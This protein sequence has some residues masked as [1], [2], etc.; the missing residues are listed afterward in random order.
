MKIK[1]EERHITLAEVLEGIS[2]ARE[3]EKELERRKEA[4][5]KFGDSPFAGLLALQDENGEFILTN[6]EKRNRGIK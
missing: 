5:A 6:E 1:T 2:E 4:A 3:D